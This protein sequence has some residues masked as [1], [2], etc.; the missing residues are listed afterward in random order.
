MEV[1]VGHV[2]FTLP[3]PTPLVLHGGTPDSPPHPTLLEGF[4]VASVKERVPGSRLLPRWVWTV[5]CEGL[6]QA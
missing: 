5:K 6:K 2:T 4:Q 3:P 1:G